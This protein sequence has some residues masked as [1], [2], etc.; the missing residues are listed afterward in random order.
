MCVVD[1]LLLPVL[2]AWPRILTADLLRYLIPAGLVFLVLWVGLRRPLAHRRIQPGF[3]PNGELWREVRYSLLTALIFSLNGLVIYATKLAGWATIYIDVAA[4]GWL[5]WGFS[6]AFLILLHDAYFYW[7]HRLMHRPRLFRLIHKAHHK[8]HNPSPWAAYSFAPAEALLHAV[9]LTVVVQVMP[10]HVLVIFIFLLHM[11][12]RNVIGHCGFELFPRGALT[13]PLLR[14]ITTVTHHD[15][16]HSRL[17]GNYG[18][19]FT[20]WDRWMG[21]EHPAYPA[22]FDA[23]T[24]RTAKAGRPA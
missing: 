8:S 11:I 20:W 3:P 4:Y 1:D 22:A 13:H 19:Y 23:V 16:H 9:F 10:L 24:A 6:L 2:S 21:T 12:L 7:M 14:A 5:Y 17:T 15:M 18:L